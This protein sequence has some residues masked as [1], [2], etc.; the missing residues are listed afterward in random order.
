ML[1]QQKEKVNEKNSKLN[2]AMPI[3][4]SSIISYMT[5]QSGKT[6]SDDIIKRL[7]IGFYFYAPNP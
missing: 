6:F 3:D 5:T 2:Y 4:N 7:S 1:Q